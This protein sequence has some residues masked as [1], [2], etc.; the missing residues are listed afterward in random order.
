VR[1]QTYA[2][3]T[4]LS[5]APTMLSPSRRLARA[6]KPLL[7]LNAWNDSA[8]AS[9]ASDTLVNPSKFTHRINLTPRKENRPPQGN[10]RIAPQTLRSRTFRLAN[11]SLHQRVY[12]REPYPATLNSTGS[13]S[14][15]PT[16][17]CL[18]PFTSPKPKLKEPLLPAQL[19]DSPTFWLFMYF[20]FNLGLTLYNK[21]VLV[22]FPFPYTLSALHAL[23]GTLGGSLLAKRGYFVP[24]Q[25]NLRDT[26]VLVAFSVLY[27][28]NIVVS[29]VSLQLVT[30]P[31][32]PL[33]LP[34]RP[35]T[36]FQFHQVVRASTPIF[37]IFFARIL[38]GTRSSRAK[39]IS[40]IPVVAGVG[41]ASVSPSL[42]LLRSHNSCWSKAR[43]ATTILP[44]RASF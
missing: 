22:H 35:F 5:S 4:R 7:P 11:A 31:V 38:F 12:H 10:D 14:P 6:S 20:C 27:A 17:L 19:P 13:V 26:A 29:N 42:P 43:L 24:P 25:L 34:V 37:T 3:T 41:F 39:K 33:T 8:L 9:N 44:L 36:S 15:T 40:L 32:R 16:E 30:V 1:Q 18:P 28:V 21:S 2:V 23:F